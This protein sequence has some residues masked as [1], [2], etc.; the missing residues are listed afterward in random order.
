M[1]KLKWL[2]AYDVAGK[3]SLGD[4]ILFFDDEGEE[5]RWKSIMDGGKNG[6]ARLL[7]NYGIIMLVFVATINELRFPRLD[8]PIK[9]RDKLVFFMRHTSPKV[10][11]TNICLLGNS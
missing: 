6:C 7:L 3:R 5:K 10:S 11:D 9:I 8:I 2:S 4:L 1:T